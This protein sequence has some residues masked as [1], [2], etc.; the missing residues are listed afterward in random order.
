MQVA[1]VGT[2]NV[3]SGLLYHLARSAR[4]ANIQVISRSQEKGMGAIMDVA[5]AYPKAASKMS[6]ASYQGISQ[7]DIIV[8]TAGVQMK[9]GQKAK[10]VLAPNTEVARSILEAASLKKAAILICLATPVD[11]ITVQIQKMSGLPYNQVFGF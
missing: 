9:A 8:L 4:V 6:C 2:G 7:A 1:V 10:D 11:D 5:S 3:G